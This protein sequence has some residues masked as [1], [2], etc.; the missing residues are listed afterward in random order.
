MN[1]TT[2]PETGDEIEDYSQIDEYKKSVYDELF[3]LTYH[4]NG[5]WNWNIV[6]NL[7]IHIRRYCLKMLQIAKERENEAIK[8]NAIND[9]AKSSV[10][11]IPKSVYEAIQNTPRR[12]PK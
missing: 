10:P 12:P 4:G 2:D 7:P 1:K 11:K 8:K 5:G 3:N 9:D 6:Y